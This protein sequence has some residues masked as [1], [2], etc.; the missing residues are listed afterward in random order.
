MKKDKTIAI[1]LALFLG[2]FGIHKFY[3]GQNKQGLFY[4]IGALVFAIIPMIF[5]LFD[6]IVYLS[7]PR[8]KFDEQFNA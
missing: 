3:L 6:V 8:A 1:L 5:S 4:L 7:T 2:T